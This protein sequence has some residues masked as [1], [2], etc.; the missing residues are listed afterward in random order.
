MK[1]KKAQLNS[2]FK[3]GFT[4]AEALLATAL[5]AIAATGVLLPFASGASLQAEGSH[6]NIAANL[7]TD[8]TNIICYQSFDDIV[9]N[10][11]GYTE[12]QGQVTDSSG[13][14]I[15]DLG[16]QL[17]ARSVSCTPVHVPQ[18]SGSAE[19]NF[20]LVEVTITYKGAEMFKLVRLISR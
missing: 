4:L 1:K 18:Q 13:T 19:E 16:Y 3:K 17:F 2:K 12:A 20:I 8:M 15:S 14:V 6:R 10:Y 11:D 7:A 5:L 9:A